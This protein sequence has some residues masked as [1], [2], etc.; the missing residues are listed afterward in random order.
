LIGDNGSEKLH[1]SSSSNG[2]TSV[3]KN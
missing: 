1:S 3:G 2:S